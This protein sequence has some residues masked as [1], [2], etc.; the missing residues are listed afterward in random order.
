MANYPAEVPVLTGTAPTA[1]TPVNG[2]TIP[3][4]VVLIVRN[5]NASAC[6]VTIATPM[7]VQGDLAVAD[8]TVSVPATTGERWINIPNDSVYVDPV[9]GLVTLS[10]FTVTATV[11]YYVLR[12]P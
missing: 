9:T 4:G 10:N 8:R 5:G 2:D 11:T 6:V 12:A 1:R 7:T 3:G